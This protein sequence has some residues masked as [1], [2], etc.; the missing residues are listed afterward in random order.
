M[1][2]LF[3]LG[4]FDKN[5]DG[6]ISLDEMNSESFDW[7]DSEDSLSE[8][9]KKFMEG[10]QQRDMRRFLAADQDLD[11]QLNQGLFLKNKNYIIKFVLFIFHVLKLFEDE[12]GGF[13]HP[14]T[15][16]VR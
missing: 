11:G 5:G 2:I 6:F 16:Q 15:Q 8:E 12:F 3:Q 10:V 9:D 4:R 7:K 1:K 14:H 13:L